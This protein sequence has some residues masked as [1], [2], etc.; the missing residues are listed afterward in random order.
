MDTY[1]KDVLYTLL[2]NPF[3]NQRIL[4]E[5]CGHSL[6]IVNRS[7]KNLVL[8]K[9]LDRDFRLTEKARQEFDSLAPRRAII[10]AAGFGMRIVPINLESPKALIEVNGEVLIE[11]TIEQL[12]EAGIFDI[13]IIV[14]FMK[15][16]F[17]YLIDK[18]A[19]KLVV[20]KE[21]SS[22]NNLHSL[23]LVAD[24]L[25]N[26]YVVPCD[27]WCNRNPY[28]KNELYS[29]YMVSDL[30]DD[31]SSVRVNRKMELVYTPDKTGG[32]GM[33]G[34]AYLSCQDS[35]FVQEKLKKF[36]NDGLHN[37]S[38]WEDALFSEEKMIVQAR[39]EHS[40]DYVEINTYEQLRDLDEDSNHLKTD[41]IDVIAKAFD[42]RP[43]EICDITVLK[44]GMTNRS[45][46]FS[47]R[48]KQYIMRIPGEGTSALI[49]RKNEAAVY[50]IV[51]GKGICDD[52]V[53]INP[54]NGYKITEFLK[55]VRVCN[56]N[57]DADLKICMKK[58]REF[59]NLK[60]KV[61]HKFD[62][63]G[64]IEFYEKLRKGVPS[65]FRDYNQTKRNVL[66][67]RSFIEKNIG[68]RCL[69]HID[70]IPDNFLFSKSSS[71]KT[72][73]SLIDWE[74]AGMQDPHVDL[75]M[76]S[77]YSYYDKLQVDHLLSIYFDGKCPDVI[78]VKVYAYM[79][80]CGF[81]W[82]NW[83]EYKASLGVEFGEYLLRQYRYAKD[84]FNLV[85]K[86]CQALG[87]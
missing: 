14:G 19:V 28:R 85:N 54:E 75:A 43:K 38:F 62:I 87:I 82:S 76:F 40:S 32:N 35:L 57:D 26:A 20:N 74:Y 84:F 33:I 1:E 49:N 72:V 9:Y 30:I 55:D 11:R 83:C 71:G 42:V 69:T 16:S 73:I 8:S 18:Y 15:E 6:G 25:D 4:A 65:V 60:L 77:I 86:E 66:S 53:Y 36:D 31:D 50:Q 41:A 70:A 52:V 2:Q 37:N 5:S 79:A 48:N 27:I 23:N 44:K 59:H 29:W 58:L 21:Y 64:Q 67:L 24:L 46:L 22:K 34:I 17:D 45:F 3:V 51:S 10:L 63:F 68:E 78:R 47:C 56:A 7:L 12:H 81:L 39:V 80:V 13:H 61:S